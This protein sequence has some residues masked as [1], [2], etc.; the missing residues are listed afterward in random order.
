MVLAKT[1]LIGFLV[2]QV[3]HL[4][5]LTL[6]KL[7]IYLTVKKNTPETSCLKNIARVRN[8]PDVT[9]LNSLFGLCLSVF[10][11]FFFL[12]FRLFVFFCK[13]FFCLFVFLSFCFFLSF[14]LDIMLIKCQ[15]GVKSQKSL[16][17]SK[18]KSDTQWL[19]HSLTQWPR[20][21][22]ELPGQLKRG[23][24]KQEVYSYQNINHTNYLC[25]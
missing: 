17:V 13:F 5:T 2:Q 25:L 19:I 6:K 23:T 4:K 3:L 8:C 14:C 7:R 15:K 10:L 11:S 12:P 9:I 24:D 18:F 1:F 22:I 16:F 20:S 21:G